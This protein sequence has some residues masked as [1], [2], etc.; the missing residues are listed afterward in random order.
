[1]RSGPV[2]PE[3]NLSLKLATP[4]LYLSCCSCVQDRVTSITTRFEDQRLERDPALYASAGLRDLSIYRDPALPYNPVSLSR[5]RLGGVQRRRRVKKQKPPNAW[6]RP[7]HP[8][9]GIV[10]FTVVDTDRILHKIKTGLDVPCLTNK[11]LYAH[12]EA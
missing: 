12:S 9:R 4:R 2:A 6:C 3:L 10:E 8:V 1:M 7:D 11:S 5:S